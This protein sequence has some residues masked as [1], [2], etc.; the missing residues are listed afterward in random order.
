VPT[1]PT[2]AE[3]GI[4]KDLSSRAQKLAAV[5]EE[6][7]EGMVGEWRGRVE[8]ETERV[9]IDLLKEGKREQNKARR[10]ADEE[11]PKDLPAASPILSLRDAASSKRPPA[12]SSHRCR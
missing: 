6:K 11:I 9:T 7:F 12:L 10:S 8:K 2:L 3:V 5:P 4:N 1:L